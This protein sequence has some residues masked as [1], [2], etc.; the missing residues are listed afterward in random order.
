M[1][2]MATPDSDKP[3]VLTE[4]EK[5]RQRVRSIAIA[6]ALATLAV[7]FFLVTIVRL[8]GHVFNRPI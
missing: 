6:F 3:I 2:M 1:G 4:E 8:G 5:R 7:I